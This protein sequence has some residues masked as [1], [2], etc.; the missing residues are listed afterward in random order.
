MGFS[1]DEMLL[2]EGH[3]KNNPNNSYHLFF[4]IHILAIFFFP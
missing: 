2:W 1:F 3:L 4:Y